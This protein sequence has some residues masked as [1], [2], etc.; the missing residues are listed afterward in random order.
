MVKLVWDDITVFYSDDSYGALMF[1]TLKRELSSHYICVD[2][3]EAV[4]INNTNELKFNT[5]GAVFVGT[6]GVGE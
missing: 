2:E 4:S 5:K 1:Q 3:A 6:F